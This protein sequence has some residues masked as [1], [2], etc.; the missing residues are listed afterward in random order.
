MLQVGLAHYLT[1]AA[2]LFTTGV[3]GIFLN[4]K[5]VIIILMSVELM[6]LA[7][8]LNLVAFSSH[9]GDLVGQVFTMFVLTVAAAEAAIGLAIVV[10]FFRNKGTIAVEEISQMRG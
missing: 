1:V 6:L 2:I 3:F 10:V 7:V 4:R 8:N 5:N 9:L